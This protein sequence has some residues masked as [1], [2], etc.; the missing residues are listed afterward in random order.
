MSDFREGTQVGAYVL[1]KRLGGGSFGEVWRGHES[2]SGRPVAIKVLTGMLSSPDTAAMRAEVET[3]AAAAASRSEN[4]VHVLGGGSDP[5]PYIVMEYI[6]GSDLA[7]LLSDGGKLGIDRTIDVG[8]AISSALGT[9]NEAGIVHRD[10]KPA[11]VMVDTQGKIKLADFGI[12][13]IVGYETMTMTGQ[14]AMT[15]AYAAP[16]VWDDD[17]PFGR[18]SHRSDL[19]AMGI[20]LFQCLTGETPFR[21]NYGA[22][23]RQHTERAPDLNALPADVPPSLRALVRSCLEKKQTD[24]PSGSA[25]CITMLG[26]ARVEL[27]ERRQK[28]AFEPSKFGSWVRETPHP[29]QPWAWLSHHETSN[30]QATVEVHFASSLEYGESLRR[31][32]NSSPQLTAFGAE[33]LLQTNRLLLHPG[34]AWTSPPPGDYSFWVARQEKPQ[35]A[36]SLVTLAMLGT[37]TTMYASLIDAATSAKV[38]I[39]PLAEDFTVL[40]DGSIHIKR[41]GLRQTTSEPQEVALTRLRNLPLDSAARDFIANASTFQALVAMAHNL[42]RNDDFGQDTIIGGQNTIIA[43]QNTVIG[44]RPT[45]AAKYCASCK[46]PL[47]STDRWCFVCGHPVDQPAAAPAE[48]ATDVFRTPAA[49]ETGALASAPEVLNTEAA[50][51]AQTSLYRTG[52]ASGGLQLELRRVS[53]K[54]ASGEYEV[55]LYNPAPRATTLNLQAYDEADRLAYS[56]PAQIMLAEGAYERLNLHVEPRKKRMLGGKKTTRFFVAASGGG[57]MGT[58]VIAEGEFDEEPSKMPLF[59]G[60]GMAVAAALLAFA[61]IGIGGGDDN[62]GSNSAKTTT[63]TPNNSAAMADFTPAPATPLAIA[64]PPTPTPIPPPEPTATP[65]PPPPPPPP[66]ATPVRTAPAGGGGGTG[67]GSG[68]AGAG[69]G[70]GGTVP[71]VVPVQPTPVPVIPTPA[72]VRVNIASATCTSSLGTAT[73][74]DAG[75]A[76]TKAAQLAAAPNDTISCTAN[77]TGDFTSI[78]WNG[79]SGSGSGNSFTTGVG[80]AKPGGAPYTVGL[81][82]N[83]GGN[84]AIANFSVSINSNAPSAGTSK[85]TTQGTTQ[86]CIN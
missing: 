40:P 22:L 33:R 43:G 82:V 15:M 59:A 55:H 72:P 48:A 9:L 61:L 8:L 10:I 73:I 3:L 34:E 81:Q 85:C 21:G 75:P 14:A 51:A 24:R 39:A 57:G 23:Y 17:S 64:V 54:G 31:A 49:V 5:I 16:E 70:G 77:V 79:P 29:T 41:P 25:E 62:N 66:T 2:E 46:E 86:V 58:P 13:K 26:R 53:A 32:V 42:Q 83:W 44:A 76:G 19:Y 18:P 45:P 68:G 63:N 60:S 4:I 69:G 52:A 84:P 65:E 28:P 20:V 47:Q 50:E 7:A 38:T 6:E 71:P 67:G 56:L 80:A 27:D 11:N 37:A 35:T 78:A 1:E 12:A 74:T 36:A 30:D